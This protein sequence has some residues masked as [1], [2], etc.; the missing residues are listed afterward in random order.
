MSGK[1][2]R[3]NNN[4]NTKTA[5]IVTGASGHLGNVLVRKLIKRG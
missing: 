3:L 5:Y 4:S 2:K 1:E